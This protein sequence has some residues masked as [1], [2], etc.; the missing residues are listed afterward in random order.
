MREQPM[1]DA[2]AAGVDRSGGVR[3]PGGVDFLEVHIPLPL[4]RL[5]KRR[6]KRRAERERM[7]SSFSVFL[8]PLERVREKGGRGR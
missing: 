4:S 8:F 5:E 6:K 1:G 7:R 3:G 2:E